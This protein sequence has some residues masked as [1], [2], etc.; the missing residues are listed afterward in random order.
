M[1]NHRQKVGSTRLS[2]LLNPI[3][4]RP[5]PLQN[6]I[7][8]HVTSNSGGVIVES[9]NDRVEVLLGIS[10]GGG[11]LLGNSLKDCDLLGRLDGD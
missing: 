5:I 9:G 7:L 8:N 2:A 1:N 11:E 4:T 3:N 10:G 6:S